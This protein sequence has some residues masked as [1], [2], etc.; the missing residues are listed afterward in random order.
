MAIERKAYSCDFKCGHNVVLVKKAME[1]H[2]SI[3]FKN[4]DR[5]ACKTC[6]HFEEEYDG[7]GMEGTP[8]NHEW[9]NWVCHAEDEN[10]HTLQTDCHLHEV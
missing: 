8:Y 9:V 7:N 2:E 1:K 4:P 5:K 6:K 3:C 10:L